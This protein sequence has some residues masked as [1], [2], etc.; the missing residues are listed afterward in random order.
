MKLKNKIVLGEGALC[1]ERHERITDRYGTVYLTNDNRP[2]RLPSVPTGAAARLVV[3][4][5]GLIAASAEP[6]PPAIGE[7]VV[8]GEGV[9]FAQKSDISGHLMV[10]VRPVDGRDY[11]WLDSGALWRCHSST[12]SAVRL[13]LHP[14]R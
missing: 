8:L 2:Y 12:V 9:V 1:W 5:L 6:N 13:E 10:G 14:V 11:E 3:I 4:P 7:E